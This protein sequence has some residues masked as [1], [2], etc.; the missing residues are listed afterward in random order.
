MDGGDYLMRSHHLKVFKAE[1]SIKFMGNGEPFATKISQ[2]L[3]QKSFVNQLIEIIQRFHGQTWDLFHTQEC[4]I[5]K[6]IR[7]NE[8]FIVMSIVKVKRKVYFG[9]AEVSLINAII[10]KM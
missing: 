2:W 5:S 7:T 4:L 1:L 6:M 9:A 8:Y 3:K 10:H